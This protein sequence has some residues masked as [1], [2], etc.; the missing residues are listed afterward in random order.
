VTPRGGKIE[1]AVERT[2][3]GVSVTV[4]DDG[5]GIAR[6]QLARIF[7]PFVQ[8]DRERDALGGGLGLGLTIV[9]NLVKRHGGSIRAHSEGRDRGAA[10]TVELPTVSGAEQPPLAVQQPRAPI[11]RAGIRVLVVDDNEDI[12]ELLSK[13]LTLEGLQTAV[14][15]SGQAA[16][17]RWRSFRPHAGVLDVGLP[18]LDGYELARRLRAEHGGEPILIAATGYGRPSDR[19]MATEAGFDCHFV[20]L[21]SVKDI[22]QALDARLGERSSPDG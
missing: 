15:Y 11:S 14:E 3:R 7:Q 9:D 2:S 10:F 8:V 6:E 22:V 21:V 19:Q 16:L 17:E 12:A 5:R 20:K 1:I 18:A 4:R 13:A